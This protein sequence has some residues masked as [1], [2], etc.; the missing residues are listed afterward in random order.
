MRPLV[1]SMTATS[2]TVFAAASFAE[3]A[4]DADSFM[5]A[6]LAGAVVAAG[7]EHRDRLL[8]AAQLVERL[9]PAESKACARGVPNEPFARHFDGALVPR[10]VVVSVGHVA[11]NTLVVLGVLSHHLAKQLHRA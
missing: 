4:L 3:A 6:P 2:S 5:V 8:V 11:V 7:L 9:G 1:V 10:C